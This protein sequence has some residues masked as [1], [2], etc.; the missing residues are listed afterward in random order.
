MTGALS[1]IFNASPV[2]RCCPADRHLLIRI[3]PSRTFPDSRSQGYS[4]LYCRAAFLCLTRLRC[5][6]FQC[7]LCQYCLLP[8]LS[9]RCPV[10]HRDR[11]SCRFLARMSRS[12]FPSIRFPIPSRCRRSRHC[13]FL[14]LYLRRP[15]RPCLHL[16]NRLY[17]L[18]LRRL[19]LEP[20]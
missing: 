11:S 4:G 15:S 10:L 12:R 3:C 17:L 9:S 16:F 2:R 1:C 5:R 8:C 14:Q 19:R 6:L 7:F 13:P 18:R 20:G